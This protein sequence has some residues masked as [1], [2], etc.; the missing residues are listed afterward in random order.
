MLQ[1]VSPTTRHV[2]RLVSGLADRLRQ[3]EYT[4]S[5]RCLPCTAVNVAIAVGLATVIGIYATVPAGLLAFLACVGVIYARGYLVPGTPTL[6]K[7]YLPPSV[8]RLFGKGAVQER[9]L[10]RGAD[11][12]VWAALADAGVTTRA[13]SDDGLRLTDAFRDR[14]HRE[15]RRYR[16]ASPSP[17]EVAATVDADDVTKRGPLA[18]SVDGARL[19]EWDSEAALVADVAATRV[20]DDW[21]ADWDEVDRDARLD[22]LLRLRFVL[23]HCPACGGDVDRDHERVDPCCQKARTY[24]WTEC[25]DCEAVVAEVAV[26]DSNLEEWAEL[27]DVGERAT[28]TASR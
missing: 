14:W 13:A 18:F 11:E 17:E 7:R 27:G 25:A 22:V 3:P 12:P 21:F 26:A 16:D 20:L 5:N 4:G 24:V 2:M 28:S 10:D 15:L 23:D 8:L 6:T 9:T 1:F 19:L